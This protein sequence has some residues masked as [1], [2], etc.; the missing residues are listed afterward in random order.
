MNK[1]NRQPAFTLLEMILV[2]AVIAIIS[3]VFWANYYSGD[4]RS[5]II[6]AQKGLVRDLRLAQTYSSSGK[7]YGDVL[8]LGGWGIAVNQASS[9]YI[10]FAD[11]NGNSRYDSGEASPAMGGRVITLPEGVSISALAPAPQAFVLFGSTSSLLASISDSNTST[12]SEFRLTF[13]ESENDSTASVLVN[14]Q[15]LVSDY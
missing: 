10:F 1:L 15:G 4:T 2:L 7:Q 11:V 14:E 12:S 13:I 8:P 3:G 9:S 6:N 5:R